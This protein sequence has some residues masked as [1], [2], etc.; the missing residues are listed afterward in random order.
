MRKKNPNDRFMIL[1]KKYH[2]RFE[3]VESRL[4]ARGG[5]VEACRCAVVGERSIAASPPRRWWR[6]CS[7]SGT[8]SSCFSRNQRGSHSY[9]LGLQLPAIRSL[10]YLKS[11][12][13]LRKAYARKANFWKSSGKKINLLFRVT[14]TLAET[15]AT[16]SGSGTIATLDPASSDWHSAPAMIVKSI[17]AMVAFILTEMILFLFHFK[18][19]KSIFEQENSITFATKHCYSIEMLFE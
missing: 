6:Q 19:T 3:H 1:L 4:C 17:R 15:E 8:N 13:L 18:S 12:N 7:K 2:I 14:S 16:L 5:W 9:R 11:H 10:D